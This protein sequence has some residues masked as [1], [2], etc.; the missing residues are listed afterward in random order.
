M[1]GASIDAA[2]S[3]QASFACVFSERDGMLVASRS[4]PR[5]A[6]PSP[7]I[8]NPAG[9]IRVRGTMAETE[10]GGPLRIARAPNP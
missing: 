6:S 3:S 9:K 1:P 4:E 5:R 8:R 7:H 2:N 10:H